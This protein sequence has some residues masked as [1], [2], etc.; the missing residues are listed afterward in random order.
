MLARHFKHVFF[1]FDE[2]VMAIVTKGGFNLASRRP[3][4][5]GAS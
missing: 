1:S 5:H 2:N 4:G 3:C